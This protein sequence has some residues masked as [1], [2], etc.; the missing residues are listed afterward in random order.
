MIIK[1]NDFKKELKLRFKFD[2]ITIKNDNEIELKLIAYKYT[3]YS[4]YL[5]LYIFI[6]KDSGFN[7]YF[8]TCKFLKCSIIYIG[9]E[10][11]LYNFI[12]C[13]FRKHIKKGYTNYIKEYYKC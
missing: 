2:K 5:S 8:K 13:M 7:V 10:E 4:S 6:N 3:S 11:E 1:I 12:E 9:S